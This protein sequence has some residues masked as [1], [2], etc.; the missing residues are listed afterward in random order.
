MTK[1]KIGYVEA[2]T[3]IEDILSKIESNE[4]DVDELSDKVK[5]VSVLLKICKEKL[6][7]TETEVENILKEIEDV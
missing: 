3:E 6:H 7:T 2:I 1:K 5:R 4:L